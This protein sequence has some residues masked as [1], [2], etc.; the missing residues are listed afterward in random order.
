MTSSASYFSMTSEEQI[1]ELSKFAEIVLAEYPLDVS[2]LQSINHGY[3]STFRV[4]TTSGE[5]FAL[6]IN[7]NSWRSRANLAAEIAW[8]QA[9]QEEPLINVARPIFNR[10]GEFITALPHE[11]TQRVLNSVVYSWLDGDD[12]GDE[13]T[14][15]QLHALGRTM[16]LLHSSSI[17][18]ALPEDAALP[19]YS[20]VLWSTRNRLLSDDSVLTDADK[21]LVSGA[22]HQIE[23]VIDRLYAHTSPQLIH[24]DL[25][26]WNVKWHEGQLSV[27]DF[28][29]CGIG[30]PIQDIATA[31][32]YLDTPEQDVAL[33]AGYASVRALPEHSLRDLET[34]LLQRR[35]ILTNDLLVTSNPEHRAMA[36]SYLAETLRRV[37]AFV[38]SA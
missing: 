31:L 23:T 16:A 29:D 18:V 5:N 2:E 9:L 24:A 35:L 14:E 26:C 34:L 4:S 32:Y 19:L 10:Q 38:H 22:F 12:L 33:L 17:N 25:H 15:Q 27:L 8:V 1:A 6:R 28:D 13:P 7:V 37:A 36:P 11:S 30:L 20:D 21:V 3:N